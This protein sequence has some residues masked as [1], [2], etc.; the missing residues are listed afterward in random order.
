MTWPPEKKARGELG[1]KAARK[2][3]ARTE[4]RA[5]SLLA[6]ILGELF[7][8]AEQRRWRLADLIDDEDLQS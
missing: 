3:I 7:W 8:F 6:N 5:L 2:L 1:S 4:Y